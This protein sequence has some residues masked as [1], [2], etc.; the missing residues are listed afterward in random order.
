[1]APADTRITEETEEHFNWNVMKTLQQREFESI[2]QSLKLKTQFQMSKFNRK[3]V[4]KKQLSGRLIKG[5]FYNTV[6]NT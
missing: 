2:K 5:T 1:M 4:G 3:F 6:N